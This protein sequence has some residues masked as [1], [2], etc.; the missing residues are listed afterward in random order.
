MIAAVRVASRIVTVIVVAVIASTLTA[1]SY[2]GTETTPASS[3]AILPGTAA[4]A[5][6][7]GA[8]SPATPSPPEPTPWASPAEGSARLLLRMKT[9]D[10]VCVEMPGTTIL[11]D[12]R[13]IWLADWPGFPRGRGLLERRLTAEGL[14]TVREALDATALLAADGTYEPVKTSA[15]D[16]GHGF[17]TYTF[18]RQTEDGLAK[19]TT[20][21]PDVFDADN[22]MHAGTWA[23]PEEARTLSDL[24]RRIEDPMA[25]LPDGAWAEP[26]HPYAP[27]AYLLVIDVGPPVE[28]ELPAGPDV[29]AVRWPFLQPLSG[30]GAPYTIDG[31]LVERSR[32]LPI[33]PETAAAMSLAEARVQPV[34]EDLGPQ[35]RD[36]QAPLDE[37][38]Y[39]WTRGPAQVMVLT[40]ILLP[41]QPI[42]C[43]GGGR[44]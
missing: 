30:V 25:W 18:K 3:A 34:D 42:T 28:G 20:V 39:R 17:T 41:D 1:C 29:D 37:R 4:T 11:E 5:P 43:E 14:Q 6:S 22:S 24:G 8:P 31:Q 10:D 2:G 27:A 16:T 32:C 12:G 15:V 44:W 40:R 23:I 9:C 13:V 21:D 7:S 33:P 26:L 38:G 35:G 19:V 36:L